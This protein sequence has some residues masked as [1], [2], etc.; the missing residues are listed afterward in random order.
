[1]LLLIHPY[2]H[3]NGNKRK[4]AP[5]GQSVKKESDGGESK[6]PKLKEAER[7]DER[8]KDKKKKKKD[9]E[10][11]R[12]SEGMRRSSGGASSSRSKV[13]NEISYMKGIMSWAIFS[14]S[15][16]SFSTKV[17][18]YVIQTKQNMK[19]VNEPERSQ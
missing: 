12:K 19:A 10:K 15:S 17:I 1:M 3:S 4:E 14:F 7:D 8:K 13:R 18:S 16:F 6:K 9:K 11:D 2:A 5:I